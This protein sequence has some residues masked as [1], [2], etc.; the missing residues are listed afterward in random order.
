MSKLCS[1]LLPIVLAACFGVNCGAAVKAPDWV[2]V[3]SDLSY[4]THAENKLDV[5]QSKR[6]AASGK[7]PAV[8]LIHGGGWV[9]GSKEAVFELFALPWL[10]K[11]FTVFN[12]EYRMAKTAV[13]PA[14]VEDVLLAAEW[15]RGNAAKYGIDKNK[16]IASGDSAGGHLA[17]MVGLTP[18]QAK[19][20]PVGKIA[21]VVNWYGITDLQDQLE[22]QNQRNYAV[23]WVPASMPDRQELA[24]RVSPITWA[25]KNDPPV[26]TIHGDE[27]NVVPY[28]H[29]VNMTKTLRAAGSDAELIPVTHGGHGGFSK[30]QNASLWQLIFNFL[31]KRK[32]L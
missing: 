13:A 26:L 11:G 25:A 29:G 7:V 22:G 15:V 2:K 27:D 28:D 9:D 31:E 5:Y 8:I 19:L 14:A 6:Q 4:G 21:A 12:V 24:R 20:G 10:E 32:L 3:E 30:E 23:A 17:L 1:R 16:I 18:K